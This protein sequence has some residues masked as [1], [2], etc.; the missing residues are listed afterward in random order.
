MGLSLLAVPSGVL[1]V[2]LFGMRSILPV[3]A[4]SD[5]VLVPLFGA[6]IFGAA[7][8]KGLLASLLSFEPLVQLGEAS[9]ALY[10]LYILH[11]PLAFWYRWGALKFSGDP[12]DHRLGVAFFG[13]LSVAFSY[14]VFIWFERPARRWLTNRPVTGFR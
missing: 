10:I 13:A 12:F 8:A 9:Y 7:Q 2:L 3:W 1:L 5:A 11:M 14:V 4:V 6:V